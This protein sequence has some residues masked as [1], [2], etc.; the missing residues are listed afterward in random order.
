MFRIALKACD[1]VIAISQLG[2]DILRQ[3]Y[4]VTSS[5]LV[6]NRL[7]LD[8][9]T[10][11]DRAPIRVISVGRFEEQK[12]FQYL[13]EAAR[14][15]QH[16]AVEFVVVGFGPLDI[17]ALAREKGVEDRIVFFDKLGQPELRLLYQKCDIYCLPSISH[18]TQGM[19]G[20]PVV[21]LEAMA[22]GLPVV[23]TSAGAVPELVRHVLVDEKSPEALA[24]ALDTL[25]RDPDLR[26]Q[27]AA[28]NR[29][30]V[31]QEYSVQNV[32]ALFEELNDIVK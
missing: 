29:Q 30:I 11:S 32:Q 17:R 22:C 18:P 9:S 13:F 23:A 31:E 16:P 20:I 3:R 6:L 14:L 10:W 28:E 21:L 24:T 2:V 8:M 15:M 4:G 26:R 5:Q 19:E 25:A 12:G 7:F 1:K 27:Y